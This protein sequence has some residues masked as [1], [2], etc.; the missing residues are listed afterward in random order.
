M[1]R[2]EH[3]EGGADR[4]LGVVLMR[5][6]DSER[7]E[8]GVA[9]ELLDDAAVGG[10]AVR[11]ALEELR[12]APARDLGVGPGDERRRIDEIDEENGRQL[13]FHCHKSMNDAGGLK[14]PEKRPVQA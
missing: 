7:R 14:N 5:L 13:S 9:R 2:V 10:D 6:R 3:R 4:A 12:H 1:D 11:D 8:H